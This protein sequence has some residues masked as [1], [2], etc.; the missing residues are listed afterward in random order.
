M[1]T[2]DAC[3][4]TQ[5]DAIRRNQAQSGAIRRNRTHLCKEG[6]IVL[7]HRLADGLSIEGDDGVHNRVEV[8]GLEVRVA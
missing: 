3:N 2:S 6:V 5:W 8:G 1:G 7:V 4:Q